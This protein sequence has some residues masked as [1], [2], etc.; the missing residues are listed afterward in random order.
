MIFSLEIE[1]QFL[2]TLLQHPEKY[3]QIADFVNHNDFYGAKS[4]VHQTIFSI[5]RQIL[6]K[7]EELDPAVIIDRVKNLGVNFEENLSVFD[8]V[9]S[10]G[11]RKTSEKALIS[12]AKELRKYTVRRD[13]YESAKSVAQEM[14]EID[15][16]SSYSDIVNTADHTFN[17]KIDFYESGENVPVDIMAEMEGWIEERGN[18]PVEDFGL[19]GPFEKLHDIYGSLL[20]PGNITVLVARSGVGKTTLAMNYATK[21]A[22]MHDVPVL[23]FDNGEMSKEELIMRQCSALSGV[24]LYLL[25]TGKW[26]QES[27]ETVQK[28]RAVWQKVKKIKFYYYS[29]GGM[30]FEDMITVLKR[31]YYSVIGRGNPM[32][33]SFDYI[34]P[35]DSTNDSRNE[36]QQ[37]GSMVNR[38]KTCISKEVLHEGS[39]IIPMFT[40]VQ[41]NKMGITHNRTSENVTDDESIVSLSDRI[42]QY[43][44]HLFIF[45]KKT[46]DELA[47]EGANFG[48]HKL[49]C[50]K[51]RHLGRD[52]AG[53]LEPV[54][55]GDRL[56]NNFVN[57]EM[58]GFDIIERGD[59]RDIVAYNQA[60][61][62]LATTE[63]TIQRRTENGSRQQDLPDFNTI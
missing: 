2:A 37:I 45:R 61:A 6:E 15:P 39:P 47:D 4:K 59:L 19:K 56:R 57:L 13:I 29:V 26:R 55:V 44:S 53:H 62:E 54:L 49:I 63:E 50:I 3:G 25:E 48:T 11:M 43:C 27:E 46:L 23:H 41:S 33:F 42:T 1:Q 24:P 51:P 35:S 8:Y 30:E 40:S 28:V 31:F 16:N 60:H 9:H 36:W 32:I 58:K 38:F 12:L 17:K 22:V 10:L 52:V 21:A 14:R 34:K 7:G 18:N 20:R 5:M